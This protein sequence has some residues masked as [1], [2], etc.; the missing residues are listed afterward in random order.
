M[1]ER[2]LPLQ[3][4]TLIGLLKTARLLRLVRVA[5]KLDRYSEYGAAVLILLMASFA[6]IAHWLACIWYAI[7]NVE[8]PGL[9]EPKIGGRKF[10]RTF[11]LSRLVALCWIPFHSI[12]TS[13][14]NLPVVLSLR[15]IAMATIKRFYKRNLS[16]TQQ[17]ALAI[18]NNCLY[19]Y[20]KC[21]W[22]S[23]TVYRRN[24]LIVFVS[25]SVYQNNSIIHSFL[26]AKCRD[27]LLL[28]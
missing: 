24:S 2:I 8:R 14:S 1:T 28:S 20:S 19:M 5:R 9:K 4:T 10:P 7:G 12:A 22:M 6:L 3:T 13:C 21:P 11:N 18:S 16:G 26:C 23:M 17:L 25:L 15:K 27:S